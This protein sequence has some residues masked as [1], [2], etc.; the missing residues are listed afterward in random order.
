MPLLFKVTHH[1]LSGVK[2]LVRDTS[3]TEVF[4][5]KITSIARYNFFMGISL[6][7]DILLI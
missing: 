3:K 4:K 2:N 1:P 7:F 6:L 5:K